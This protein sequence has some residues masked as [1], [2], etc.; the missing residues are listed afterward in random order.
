MALFSPFLPMFRQDQ[1]LFDALDD[2]P[3]VNLQSSFFRAA[4]NARSYNRANVSETETEYKLEVEVPGYQKSEI[5]LE[6]GQDGKVLIVSG[7]TE[8]SYEEGTPPGAGSARG[9][10]VEEVPE[11]GEKPSQPA[12]TSTAVAETSKDTSVGSP[13]APKYW[14]SERSVGSFSR[15]FSLPAGLDLAKASASLE[16][17]VLTVVIPKAAKQNV[18]KITIA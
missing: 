7:K 4:I 18:R 2:H 10:T 6:Y 8:K 9:V 17:G 11:E 16:H 15:S 3:F 12:S 13:A 14:V 5:N 1:S